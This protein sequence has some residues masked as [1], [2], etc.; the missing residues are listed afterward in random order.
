MPQGPESTTSAASP[1]GPGRAALHLVHGFAFGVLGAVA[2]W[3]AASW[4]TVAGFA[5]AAAHTAVFV[6][7]LSRRPRWIL[8]A[9]RAASIASLSFLAAVSWIA[10]ASAL[11]LIEL[12]AGI[13]AA[14]TAGLFTVWASIALFTLPIGVW[15]LSSPRLSRPLGKREVAGAAL[16]TLVGALSVWMIGRSAP[17][18]PVFGANDTERVARVL[19]EATAEYFA[20]P[21]RARERQA[22]EWQRG[23]PVTCR[24]PVTASGYTLLVTL[25]RDPAVGLSSC[26]QAATAERLAARFAEKL[27]SAPFRVARIQADLVTAQRRL[28]RVHPIFDALELRPAIDGVC[29]GTRCL[30]PWQLVARGVFTHF[31]PIPKVP[32]ARF[33][34]SLEEI[35]TA[36]GGSEPLERIE[37]VSYA[38]DA[39]GWV[40]L[41]RLRAPRGPLE[42][43]LVE[44]TIAAAQRYIVEHQAEDGT[45]AYSIDPFSTEPPGADVGNVARQ[46]GAALV[47]CELGSEVGVQ[48]AERAL[49][50]MSRLSREGRGFR[51]VSLR[52]DRA[53]LGHSALPL[54]ALLTCRKRPEFGGRSPE[55]DALVDDLARFVLRMQRADG[56]FFEEVTLPA[57]APEGE[58]ESLFGA[59]QAVLGLVLLER[60]LAARPRAGAPARETLNTAIRRAMDHYAERHW[61]SA[62][63]SL[64]FL[65]ENWHCLAA[66]AALTA[67]RHDGYERFCLDY[68]AFKERFIFEPGTSIPANVGG[69]GLGHLF[70]LHVTPAAGFA[71]ALSAA[72]SVKKARGMDVTSD[73]SLLAR[74]LGFVTRQQW[75][76]RACGTCADLSVIGGFSESASTPAVR[77]DYVQ[78]AMAALGHGG[79]LLGFL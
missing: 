14:V 72:L 6:T 10:A 44:T 67:H 59:G 11:Y 73:L 30:S 74:T 48:S 69:Y 64:F 71:E 37:T 7:W 5:L 50:L 57:G 16:T 34:S 24:D 53:Q 33:G 49:G 1:V 23:A 42:P 55:T 32:D 20:E 4:L 26:L 17:P 45:Y 43:R 31:S 22:P 25:V 61:P 47:L 65:E 46:A 28:R 18:A 51:A 41:D 39:E 40:R 12:Y 60:E 3:Q 38:G 27:R 2:P 63:R 77:V 8:L 56:S 19:A 68:V 66:R 62:L 13:G 36:L 70:P 52:E 21:A 78:H 9:L 35:A 15:G 58:R 76:A 75:D 54:C 79:K 29:Q